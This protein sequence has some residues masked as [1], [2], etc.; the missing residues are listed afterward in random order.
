MARQHRLW[1]I[2]NGNKSAHLLPELE[3]LK[4][5]AEI[6]ILTDDSKLP[7]ILGNYDLYI[8]AL[9]PPFKEEY[10]AN[11]G[12]L[13]AIAT[14][15]TGLD[16]LPAPAIRKKG[17]KLIGLR[18]NP[19]LLKKVTSTAEMA[20]TLLLS[21]IRHIPEASQ[22]SL[23]GKWE[24]DRFIGTQLSGKTMGIIGYGRLGRMVGRYA[25]AFGMKVYANDTN[26]DIVPEPGIEMVPLE[27]LLAEA[28]AVSIHIHLDPVNV[29]FFDRAK[30]EMMKKEAVLVNTSRGAVIN[31]QDFLQALESGRIAGAAV[32]VIAGEGG[33][34]SQNCLIQYAKTHHNMVIT[35]HCGGASYEAQ[36][37][38]F[39]DIIRRVKE[40]IIETGDPDS[41]TISE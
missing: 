27:K 5:Y 19:E 17:I 35:P 30:F 2:L 13:K 34:L 21:L 3:P 39:A 4:P 9:R 32:D 24:R 38:T 41:V 6:D 15:T 11:C 7:E 23:S 10:L 8:T 29:G 25:Q 37:F 18:E 28:D 14:P 26:P 20:W 33:D 16:H 36:K 31:E 22:S 12:K 40:Y 1:R